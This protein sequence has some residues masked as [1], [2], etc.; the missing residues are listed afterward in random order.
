M[1]DEKRSYLNILCSY[2]YLRL[3]ERYVEQLKQYHYQGKANF[4]LDSGAFTAFVSGKEIELEKYIE[5]C[6]TNHN[7]FEKYV[8]LDKVGDQTQ[9]KKNYETMLSEGLNPMFV[10]TMFDKDYDYIRYA[11]NNQPHLC[12]AGGVTVKNDWTIKRF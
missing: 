8:M 2:A 9:T 7:Y 4:M 11:V 1:I 3:N 10:C 5:F 6:Q 12:V